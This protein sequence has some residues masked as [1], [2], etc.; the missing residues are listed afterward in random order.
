MRLQEVRSQLALVAGRLL[1]L[2]RVC[3]CEGVLER[4]TGPARQ[5]Q[6][7][8]HRRSIGGG[9]GGGACCGDDSTSTSSGCPAVWLYLCQCMQMQPRSSI[10]GLSPRQCCLTAMPLAARRHVHAWRHACRCRRRRLQ[11]QAT[12]QSAAEGVKNC[13]P[14]NTCS[15][16]AAAAASLPR[17]PQACALPPG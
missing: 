13:P 8:C 7:A 14:D 15:C 5:C 11:T 16:A 12:L 1:A 3:R 10:P 2:N 4:T 17:P 9:G 6:L